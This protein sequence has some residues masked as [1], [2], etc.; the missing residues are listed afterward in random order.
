[1]EPGD[2]S[3]WLIF[4]DW[5]E[6]AGRL[7]EARLVRLRDRLIT[8]TEPSPQ[9][10]GE[11][12]ELVRLL[13]KRVPVPVATTTLH[14]APSVPLVFSLIA[15]GEF[16]MGSLPEELERYDNEG[17]RHRVR[18]TRPFY[19]G[20]VPVTQAQWQAVMGT[21]SFR[22]SGAT[23]PADGVN[24]YDAENFCQRLT[25][26]FQ[27]HVRLPTEAEWEYACRGGTQTAF[28][29]GDGYQS[30]RVIGWCSRTNPGS[31][32]S[33]RP[34]G[35]LLPNPWGLYDMHGN[36]REWCADDQRSYTEQMQIDPRG[37]E[38]NVHRI[39][40]GGSWYYTAEDARSA[41]RYQRPMDYRLEYYGFRVA[42]SIEEADVHLSSNA[43][44]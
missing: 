27:R 40:R 19:L 6:E 22:F 11:Q 42:L 30:M 23:R 20:I 33:T 44:L 36:V 17:P 26:R 24:A 13:R 43:E 10:L 25:E 41:S 12:R 2:R 18:I 32:R 39:V 37:P 14:L 31:A 5:L 29:S 8:N 34:V 38:S 28:V 7:P 15:P 4:S 9:R 1:V 35:S 3:T 16:L 21:T